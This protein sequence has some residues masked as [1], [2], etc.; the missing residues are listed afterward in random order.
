MHTHTHTHTQNDGC[1][2]TRGILGEWRDEEA[3]CRSVCQLSVISLEEPQRNWNKSSERER[4]RESFSSWKWECARGGVYSVWNIQKEWE[5]LHWGEQILNICSVFLS[6]GAVDEN[7]TFSTWVHSSWYSKFVHLI[8]INM[9]LQ[10]EKK[11]DL[12]ILYCISCLDVSN[13][14]KLSMHF[15]DK[16]TGK[17]NL[18]KRHVNKFVFIYYFHTLHI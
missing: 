4:V 1:K 17:N 18:E 2:P 15:W 9:Y 10:Y 3:L 16:K 12:F 13:W 5:R 14:V 7:E 8:C 6:G 11:N